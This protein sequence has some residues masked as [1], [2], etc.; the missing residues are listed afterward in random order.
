MHLAA[1][2]FG[3]TVTLMSIQVAVDEALLAQAGRAAGIH[4][5]SRIVEEGLRSLC[6]LGIPPTFDFE[7]TLRA[8]EELPDLGEAGFEEMSRE[9]NASLPD[10]WSPADA[11]GR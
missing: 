6:R 2:R 4:N 9:M 7:E 11:S 3:P 1:L 10:A 8:A 5:P